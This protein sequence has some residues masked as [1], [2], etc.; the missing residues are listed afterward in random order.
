MLFMKQVPDFRPGKLITAHI[1]SFSSFAIVSGI[2]HASMTGCI[3]DPITLKSVI[4]DL[5]VLATNWR[6]IH[7]FARSAKCIQM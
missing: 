2:L 3:S 1:V 6:R 5:E 4:R 7:D